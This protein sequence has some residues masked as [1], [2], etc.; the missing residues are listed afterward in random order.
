MKTQTL[1]LFFLATV[2]V[3]GV[4]WVFLLPYLS[5]EKNME[6]RK[7]SVAAKEPVAARSARGVQKSRR[8]EV[9]TTLKQIEQK[10][11]PRVKLEPRIA[12]AGL[13]WS[14]RK[15][16]IIAACMGVVVF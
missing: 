5:G 9:E 7:A 3:G 13:N 16:Y 8:D 4:A 14:K 6:K 10:S 12:Q 11:N 15:F 1:A 2:A